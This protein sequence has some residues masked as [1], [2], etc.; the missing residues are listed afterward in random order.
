MRAFNS[1]GCLFNLAAQPKP[2]FLASTFAYRHGGFF[3]TAHH[4]IG[5]LSASE[6][7]VV[8]PSIDHPNPI[9][10]QR[11][12]AHPA[13]DIAILEAGSPPPS[14][15]TPFDGLSALS[16]WGDEIMAF[17]YPEESE[18]GAPLPTARLL[19]GTVQRRFTFT[20]RLGYRYKTGESSFGSPAGMSGGPV[21][22][23]REVNLLVGVMAENHDSTT[24]L[25][26]VE[27][28]LANGEVYKQYQHEV[29]RYGIYVDLGE[30]RPWLDALTS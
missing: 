3:L 15:L 7:E 16:G 28:A 1:V 10:V 18:E 26:S 22:S 20:S 24:Y 11:I 29:I 12:H 25:R 9:P 4:C 14:A 2:A 21:F 13:A 27:E 8:L 23:T 17:G 5:G 19:T 30:L 6:V